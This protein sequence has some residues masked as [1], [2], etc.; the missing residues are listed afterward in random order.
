[1]KRKK[2]NPDIFRYGRMFMCFI[3]ALATMSALNLKYISPILPDDEGWRNIFTSFVGWGIGQFCC[4]IILLRA[5]YRSFCDNTFSKRLMI[6]SVFFAVSLIIGEC[7]RNNGGL[8]MSV[9]NFSFIAKDIIM[10]AGYGSLFYCVMEWLMKWICQLS[11][12][13]KNYSF[14]GVF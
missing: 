12:S 6:I 3:F 1:M 5:Y 4:V 7:Y 10:I 8:G 14:G 2:S 11:P 9:C 13:Q